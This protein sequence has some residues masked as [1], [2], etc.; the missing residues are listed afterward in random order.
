MHPLIT[1]T[2]DF[3]E[4]DPF[5]AAMKGVI[6][7]IS[8][9]SNIIDLTHDI[10]PQDIHEAAYFLRDS[11]PCFPEGSVHIVVVDPGVGTDRNPIAVDLDGRIVVCP[12]NGLIGWVS[13]KLPIRKII[14]LDTDRCRVSPICHT[15]HGRDVF[16]P[17]AAR[18]ASGSGME[19]LGDTIETI[20]KLPWPEP[21]Q[22]S[23]GGIE[24]EVMHI[25]RFGNCITNIP[26]E[27]VARAPQATVTIGDTLSAAV[28]R[29]YADVPMGAPVAYVGSGGLIEVAIN[30]GNAAAQHGIARGAAASMM[31]DIE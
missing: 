21:K 31:H 26:G 25:D 10:A 27:W 2:T 14:I 15:F 23:S 5:V 24:G 22:L 16:A 30:R 20:E 3:G 19:Q 6:S 8:P 17:A 18:I 29:T 12:D 1:L 13:W 9:Q 7:G 28:H 4:R 11:L